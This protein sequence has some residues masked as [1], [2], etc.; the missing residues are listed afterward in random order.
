MMA[1]MAVER[2]G[3][4]QTY[5][6]GERVRVI[7]HAVPRVD[8]EGVIE[9]YGNDAIRGEWVIIRDDN[10]DSQEVAVR[11]VTSMLMGEASNF[12]DDLGMEP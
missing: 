1:G 6:I 4:G 11:V 8:I 2:V 12:P 3:T 5:D 10:G 7:R 9:S